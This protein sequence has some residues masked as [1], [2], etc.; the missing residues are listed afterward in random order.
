MLK[1]KTADFMK[2]FMKILGNGRPYGIHHPQWL[3]VSMGIETINLYGV[4][5][6]MAM[7]L[8]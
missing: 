1:P 2:E 7:Q 6:D 8:Y 4:V 3:T 5:Y